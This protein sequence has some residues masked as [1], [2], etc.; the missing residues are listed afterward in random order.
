MNI[1]STQAPPTQAGL[2]ANTRHPAGSLVVSSGTVY[3][4]NQTTKSY[5]SPAVFASYNYQ[6]QNILP[7][8]AADIA[9]PT[10]GPASF[11]QGTMLYSD[12]G[13]YVVGQ[14]TNGTYKQPVGPWDCY[15]SRLHYTANDWISIPDGQLPTRTGS[16]FTC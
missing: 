15:Q 4:V 3:I 16:L 9:L 11:R 6:W 2:Y 5:L 7:A 10:D 14:D 8:T 12:G 13:I 1:P